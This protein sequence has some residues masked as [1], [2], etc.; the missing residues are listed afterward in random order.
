MASKKG[1]TSK[2]K[3]V[4]LIVVGILIVGL[5]I[6]LEVYK[7]Y[8]A[9]I[10]LRNIE[11]LHE[12]IKQEEWL[13][14]SESSSGSY[15]CDKSCIGLGRQ[16]LVNS[17][18]T[19]FLSYARMYMSKNDFSVSDVDVTCSDYADST[20]LDCFIQGSKENQRLSFYVV[21]KEDE[22]VT[23]TVGAGYNSHFFGR[24]SQK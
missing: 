5:I 19:E 3:V 21:G 11:E 4:V 1:G 10:A 18:D 16:Y 22:K 12:E 23:V 24:Y 20:D 2:T 7:S 13:Q 15:K 6:G 14:K 9:K 8:D 17:S